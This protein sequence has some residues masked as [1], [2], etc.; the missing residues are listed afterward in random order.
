MEQN[1]R[2]VTIKKICTFLMLVSFFLPMAKG[3]SE[4][5]IPNTTDNPFINWT[6]EN[7]ET[8]YIQDIYFPDGIQKDAV[9]LLALIF[10]WPL[11]FLFLTQLRKRLTLYLRLGGELLFATLGGYLY[12][13]SLVF[14]GDIMIGGIVY[15]SAAATYLGTILVELGQTIKSQ[16]RQR[17]RQQDHQQDMG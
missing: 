8:Y 9:A 13:L 14:L 16:L 10:F 3:C 5:K 7:P 11:P 6:T 2:I 15:L 17:A 1:S 12:L 4:V